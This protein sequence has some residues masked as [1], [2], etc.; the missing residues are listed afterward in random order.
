MVCDTL[1]ATL[2]RVGSGARSECVEMHFAE[3]Q[4]VQSGVRAEEGGAARV[5]FTVYV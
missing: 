1:L 2:A 4:G 5:T 3:R